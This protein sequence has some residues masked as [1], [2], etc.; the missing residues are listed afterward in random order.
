MATRPSSDLTERLQAAGFVADG[1]EQ[2]M[3]LPLDSKTLAAFATAGYNVRGVVDEKGLADYGEISR[4]IG[5]QRRDE[6]Q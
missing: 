1:E 2:V 5:R 4:Q 6:E 3:T